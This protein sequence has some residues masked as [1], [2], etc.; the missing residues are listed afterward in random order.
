MDRN[1][2]IKVLLGRAHLHRDTKALQNLAAGLPND[3][4]PDDLLLSSPPHEPS[5][6]V[7]VVFSLKAPACCCTCR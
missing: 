4:Q 7:L 6:Y 3:V 2:F 1:A 5:L